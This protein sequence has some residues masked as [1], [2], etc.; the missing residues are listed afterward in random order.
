MTGRIEFL[1]WSYNGQIDEG[2][3]KRVVAATAGRPVYLTKVRH[4]YVLALSEEM[5][6]EDE[7]Q[8]AYESHAYRW[9]R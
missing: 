8:R 3:V 5:L 7:A 4:A 9:D 6:T 1:G 2:D